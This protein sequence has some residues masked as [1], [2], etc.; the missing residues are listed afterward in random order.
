MIEEIGTITDTGLEL[1]DIL[2]K[3]R[4]ARTDVFIPLALDVFR[5]QPKASRDTWADT[6]S[7]RISHHPDLSEVEIEHPSP[8]TLANWHDDIYLKLGTKAKVELSLYRWPESHLNG[9]LPFESARVGQAMAATWMPGASHGAITVAQVRWAHL[10]HL[11][12]PAMPF[13]PVATNF[14][15]DWF[16]NVCSV[17][18]DLA[19]IDRLPNPSFLWRGIP[20]ERRVSFQEV[21]DDCISWAPWTS[22]EA[23]N[24]YL[25]GSTKRLLGPLAINHGGH[26][27]SDEYKFTT[28]LSFIAP[29]SYMIG[30]IEKDYEAAFEELLNSDLM[31]GVGWHTEAGRAVVQAIVKEELDG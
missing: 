13:A 17:S 31:R 21:V 26:V 3:R 15:G 25:A 2:E 7:D 8:K 10:L 1:R 29:R 6:L 30:D 16:W 24:Q 19:T 27:G 9:A 12:A 4:K 28:P 18:R 5:D 14:G 22:D 20:I 23:R 11:T